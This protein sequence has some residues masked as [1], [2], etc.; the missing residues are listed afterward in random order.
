VEDRVPAGRQQAAAALEPVRR[1]AG[2][3]QMGDVVARWGEVLA[4]LKPATQHMLRF[5]RPIA[6]SKRR[7]V[8]RVAGPHEYDFLKRRIGEI[9]QAVA[10]VMGG[11]WGVDLMTDAP[12]GESDLAELA[13]Q[14]FDGEL[15]QPGARP[16]KKDDDVPF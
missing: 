9:G 7:L 2:D 6:A 12:A 14:M 10:G 8:L 5:A 4:R 1:A 11:S 15:I 3:D 16:R 13:T